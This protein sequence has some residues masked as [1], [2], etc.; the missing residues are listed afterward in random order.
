MG[1]PENFWKSEKPRTLGVEFWILS[2]RE[3]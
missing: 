1:L 3:I 2:G